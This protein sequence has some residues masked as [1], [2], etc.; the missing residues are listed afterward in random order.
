MGLCNTIY[1]LTHV[2][3]NT[4]SVK[5]TLFCMCFFE[6]LNKPRGDRPPTTNVTEKGTSAQWSHCTITNFLCHRRRIICLLRRV[7]YAPYFLFKSDTTHRLVQ[8]AR[9]TGNRLPVNY[10]W[11]NYCQHQSRFDLL[12]IPRSLMLSWEKLLHGVEAAAYVI[13]AVE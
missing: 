8:T 4:L 10:A 6:Q 5:V 9:I 12:L 13:K 1:L 2:W 3:I 11:W 7:L